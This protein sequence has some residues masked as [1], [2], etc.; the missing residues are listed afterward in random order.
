MPFFIVSTFTVVMAILK[1]FQNESFAKK[2]IEGIYSHHL[3]MGLGII[4][5]GF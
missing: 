3:V 2:D 4:K 1:K 5:L